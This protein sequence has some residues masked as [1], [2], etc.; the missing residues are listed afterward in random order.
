MHDPVTDKKEYYQ[1]LI[2]NIR[3][4]IL[5]V[6]IIIFLIGC[7]A[8]VSVSF[9][10]SKDLVKHIAKTDQKN[11]ATVANAIEG[12]K[13]G[14]FDYLM[15]PCN[16]EDLIHKIEKAATKKFEHEEKIM[17]ARAREITGHMV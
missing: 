5:P 6:S 13:R 12:M 11:E 9:T 10:L 4:R 15:K 2:R 1:V 14:A 17:E 3:I 8:I 16:L 7:A